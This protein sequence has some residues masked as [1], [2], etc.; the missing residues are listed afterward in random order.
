MD[1][2][3]TEFGL[4]ETELPQLIAGPSKG[5]NDADA[6]RFAFGDPEHFIDGLSEPHEIMVCVRTG[7]RVEGI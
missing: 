4:S 5:Q 7:F 6:C 3:N 1:C 2:G